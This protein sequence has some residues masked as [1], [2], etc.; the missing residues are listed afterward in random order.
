MVLNFS[1]LQ[2]QTNTL[3]HTQSQVQSEKLQICKELFGANNGRK[4]F[5]HRQ[6]YENEVQQFKAPKKLNNKKNM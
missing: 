5:I 6:Q 2:A 4:D 1:P 3:T